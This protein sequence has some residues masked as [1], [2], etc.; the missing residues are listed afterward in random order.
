MKKIGKYDLIRRDRT[1]PPRPSIWATTPL[2]NA[3]SPSRSRRRTSSGTRKKG[4]T[5]HPSF[6]E[7]GLARRQAVAPAHRPDLRC[8]HWPNRSAILSWNT[9]KAVRLSPA[10][11]TPPAHRTSRRSHFSNAR[12]RLISL[13]G[14]AS[15]TATSNR[16][17][18]SLP[19][20]V[21]NRVISRFPTSARHWSTPLIAHRFRGSRPPM[22]PQQVRELPL[23][24]QTD[25]YSLGVVMYQLLTGQLPFQ[26][27]T[28]Y[29][30]VYQIINTEPM[31]S[32]IRSKY[33]KSSTPS[34]RGPWPGHGRPATRPWENS[35]T[36]WRRLSATNS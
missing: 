28:N 9:C 1:A 5:L 26:A 16:R 29:N 34:S 25:I 27:S 13:T 8:R 19:A 3:T 20:P 21:R 35:R 24:H 10:A 12:V 23:D 30:I 11:R 7:R 4:K 2:P 6:P 33:R 22:S 14:S 36:I 17:T 31:P 18:F 15:P 32:A